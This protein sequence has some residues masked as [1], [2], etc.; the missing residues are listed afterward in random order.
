MARPA[1][2]DGGVIVPW[3]VHTAYGD[4]R[5]IRERLAGMAAWVDY[6]HDANPNL[7]WQNKRN[8]DFGD[9]LSVGA[10]TSKELLATAYFAYSTDL[11]ARMAEVAG[12]TEMAARYRALRAEY[13]GC[14]CPG[15]H[16]R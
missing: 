15:V 16:R 4:T 7:L 2:G 8:N 1:W 12:E 14:L 13:R 10:D 6:L 9:W 5:V 3:V 11:L